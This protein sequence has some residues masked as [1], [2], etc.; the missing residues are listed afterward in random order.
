[1]CSIT[2]FPC[3]SIKHAYTYVHVHLQYTQ[4]CSSNT[5]QYYAQWPL[6][7]A[8]AAGNAAAK[9]AAAGNAAAG[10]AAAEN[11]AAGNA[12]AGNV[13]AGN[14]AAENA[15]VE[16]AAAGKHLDSNQ[17]AAHQNVKLVQELL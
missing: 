2:N 14:A 9:N 16:N 3:F 7:N 13:A 5:H 10:N 15:A 6:Q 17:V 11:A 1:M 4:H 12:A 8:A